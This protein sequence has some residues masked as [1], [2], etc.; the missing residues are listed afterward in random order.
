MEFRLVSGFSFLLLIFVRLNKMTTVLTAQ[1]MLHKAKCLAELPDGRVVLIKGALPGETVE[2]ELH[3][4]K[5]V[6]QGEVLR[7]LKESPFRI[8]PSEHPGLD[9]SFAVYDYQ[10]ELKREV[11]QDAIRRA[12]KQDLIVK[13]PIPAPQ[14]WRYRSSVQAAVSPLGLGYRKLKSNEI[15][16]LNSDPVANEAINLLWKKIAELKRPK[17]INEIVFRANENEVLL[18]LVARASA[19]NYLDYAHELLDIGVAGVSYARYDRRGRFRKGSE[20][21]AGKRNILQRY[22]DFT[23]TVNPRSFAQP[24]PPAAGRMFKDIGKLLPG[25]KNMLELYAGSGIISM[26]LANSYENILATEIDKSAIVRGQRD[27]TRLGI[28]NIEFQQANAKTFEIP[29]GMDLIAI[30]PPRAG[31]SAGARAKLSNSKAG[32]I[33]YVSCDVVT[34]AR[35]VADFVKQGWNLEYFQAYDFYPHTHHIEMLSLLTR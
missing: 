21:L 18:A 20:R 31:L 33:L 10:L 25:G 27:A 35:D 5:G 17:G 11:I 12:L 19:G 34:W 23:I 8:K 26:H 22:G 9:Y 4:E 29:T 28:D 13:K 1:R 32:Q 3:N 6:L 15:V 2:V 24:N 7:V 16:V 30:D 14:I